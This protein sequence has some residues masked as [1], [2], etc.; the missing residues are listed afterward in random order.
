MW[1]L[2]VSMC[3]KFCR[4][5]TQPLCSYETLEVFFFLSANQSLEEGYMF[6]GTVVTLGRCCRGLLD[7]GR[8]LAQ[9]LLCLQDRVLKLGFL[10]D[11]AAT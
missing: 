10:V 6:C 3:A 1:Q 11:V 4:C 7:R 5:F 8:L 9:L 2:Q